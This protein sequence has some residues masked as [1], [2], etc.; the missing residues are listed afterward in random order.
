MY[1]LLYIRHVGILYIVP[2]SSYLALN[3]IMTFK[4][5]LEVTQGHSLWYHSKAW[6][7]IVTMAL[8]CIISETKARRLSKIAV[9]HTP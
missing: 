8:C 4:P 5:R 9:F 3:N 6:H 2:F 7:F 1:D